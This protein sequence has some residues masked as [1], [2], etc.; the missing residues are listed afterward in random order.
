MRRLPLLPLTL[1]LLLPSLHLAAQR[2]P[3]REFDWVDQ[4]PLSYPAERPW[5][6]AMRPNPRF[7]ITVLLTLNSNSYNG[8]QY[9][10]QGNAHVFNPHGENLFFHYRCELTFEPYRPA[11]F[12]ARWI[13]PQRKLEILLLKPGTSHTRRCRITTTPEAP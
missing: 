13:T 9:S 6:A 12:Q 3:N 8:V 7:P 2:F 10:G 4:R 1:F 11:E 5:V